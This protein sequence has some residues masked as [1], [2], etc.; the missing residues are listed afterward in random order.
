[1]DSS[2]FVL[3]AWFVISLLLVLSSVRTKNQGSPPPAVRGGWPLIGNLFQLRE[4]KPAKTFVKWAEKYGPIFTV[5]MGAPTFVVINSSDLA[6]EAMITR[7]SSISSRKLPNA[8]QIMSGHKFMVS[9]SDF[10]EEYKKLKRHLLTSVVAAAP[11]KRFRPYREE[12]VE[13][14]VKKFHAEV[15][16]NPGEKI[17][18]REFM[19][20]ELMGLALKQV[21]GK[22]L[23]SIYV[24]EL[25]TE[26]PK[27]DVYRKLLE[28][29]LSLSLEPDWRDFFPYLRWVPNKKFEMKIQRWMD[30][31]EAIIKAL[32]GNRLED[33][34]RLSQEPNNYLDSYLKKQRSFRR[35]N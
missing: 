29:P 15:A 16:A 31:R 27:I 1:M 7:F 13:N 17:M 33:P 20:Y 4:K 8:I 35:S 3:A 28:D 23:R 14:L 22:D 32:I 11:Q 12:V 26:I 5:K 30:Q 21:I 6:K 10:G 24:K 34:T 25:G 18:V 9:M 19:K 2:Q